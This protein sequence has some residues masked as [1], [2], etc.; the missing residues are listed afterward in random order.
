V[1]A[2]G[3]FAA[4]LFGGLFGL[5][6]MLVRRADGKTKVP[7]GPWMILGA[8]VG[9]AWGPELWSAYVGLML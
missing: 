2:V 5:T 4:F 6:L 8:A 9:I 3:G 7:F 1:L